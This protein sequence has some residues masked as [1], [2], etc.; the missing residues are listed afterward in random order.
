MLMVTLPGIATARSV[1]VERFSRAL[2]GDGGPP[3]DLAPFEGPPG[4]PGLIG[5]GSVTWQ[6]HADLPSMLVGG[7]AALILQTLHP[8]A[9]A[10][11]ADHSNFREDPT[12]RLQRTGEFVVTTTFANTEHS[13][14]MIEAV[15]RVHDRVVG[16]APD[17]RRYEA[18]DPD[19]LTWVHTAEVACFLRAYRRF[20]G[21][22]LNRRQCDR[23][24]DEVAV[25]A[26]K[27]GARSVPKS[28][29]E[30]RAY[31]RRIQPELMASGQA[32]ET[33]AF[34]MGAAPPQQ[35]E[36]AAYELLLRAAIGIVPGWARAMLGL[37][38]AWLA[39]VW[40]RPAM[41]AAATSLKLA[42]GPA[43]AVTAAHR[44]TRARTP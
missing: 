15:K 30:M 32:I 44:R 20:S 33:V 9:M 36:R 4:D 24:F 22:R 41:F 5:P 6:V 17:G 31:F 35:P 28:Y 26:E 7:F 10:G 16:I 14:R 2:G 11:V 21:H 12:G 8:L 27:L 19:L 29:S 43:E 42:L 39:D 18:N 23:Y 37:E 34:I 1:I 38:H 25:V 3:F 40:S 13:E